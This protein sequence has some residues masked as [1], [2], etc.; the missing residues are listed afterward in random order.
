MYILCKRPLAYISNEEKFGLL[1]FKYDK[2][3]FVCF[4]NNSDIVI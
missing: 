3:F 2:K 1:N 4:L